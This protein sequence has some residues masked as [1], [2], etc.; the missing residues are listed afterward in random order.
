MGKSHFPTLR[1]CVRSSRFMQHCIHQTLKFRLIYEILK[2]IVPVSSC[3]SDE[4][5]TVALL[6]SYNW[7]KP[8]KHFVIRYSS[9]MLTK[10]DCLDHLDEIKVG[11]Q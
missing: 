3:P 1:M 10:L 11:I 9:I 4:R 6:A 5:S 7:S 2:N 8:S